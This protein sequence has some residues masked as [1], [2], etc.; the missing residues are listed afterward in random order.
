MLKVGDK[1]PEFTAET[2][3]GTKVSLKD[4]RGKKVVLYFYPKDDTS[5]CTREACSFRDN[6]KAVLAQ[7][8]V[9]LG[10]STD[11]VDSHASFKKKYDL[12]FPLVSDPDQK[13]VTAYGVWQEKSLM[14]KTYMG[15]VR[16]TFIIDEQGKI[17]HIF[18]NVKVDGHVDEVLAAL[19]EPA[20]AR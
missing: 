15:T 1:A 12:P 11:S 20:P 4:F 7:G 6:H 5:G 16:T 17:S 3:A 19:R 9:V 13:I 8:A 2:D 14:G 10:V 18:P